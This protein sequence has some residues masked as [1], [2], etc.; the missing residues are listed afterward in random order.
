MSATVAGVLTA[1]CAWDGVV[2]LVLS[3]GAGCFALMLLPRENG[4]PSSPGGPIRVQTFRA[5][6]TC[7]GLFAVFALLLAP[8]ATLPPVPL[9]ELFAAPLFGTIVFTI[10]SA[11]ASITQ[12]RAPDDGLR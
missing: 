1:L 7:M 6:L 8:L 2:G 11:I 4:A 10:E 9:A 5:W 12:C 3:L